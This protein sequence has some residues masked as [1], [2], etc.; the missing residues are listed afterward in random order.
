M[1]ADDTAII[2]SAAEKLVRER[3]VEAMSYMC[4][5]IAS[6][7]DDEVGEQ[8]LWVLD[9]AWKG[10]EVP[11]VPSLLETVARSHEGDAHRGAAEA[12]RWLGLR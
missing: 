12:L 9:T 5:A 10:G 1:N 2:Q 6:N 11:E 3:T 7:G 4:E 8:I